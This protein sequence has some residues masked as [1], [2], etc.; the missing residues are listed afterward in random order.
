MWHINLI[1]FVGYVGDD[2]ANAAAFDSDGWLKTGDLCYIDQDGFLY[3]IDRLKELIKYKGYQVYRKYIYIVSIPASK[4]FVKIIYK[5]FIYGRSHLQSWRMCFIL[6]PMWRMQRWFRMS[7]E[8]SF[9]W[10]TNI[11]VYQNMNVK[12]ITRITIDCLTV[13]LWM[14]IYAGFLMMKSG[15]FR[16]R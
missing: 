12:L 15:K 2:E 5:C 14:F 11:Y 10:I 1:D 9:V 7:L 8:R 16:R 4:L 6:I 3:I 13:C